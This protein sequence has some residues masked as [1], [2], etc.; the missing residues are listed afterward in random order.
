MTLQC[1]I[2]GDLGFGDQTKGSW[3]DHIARL[4]RK[5]LN[6]RFNGSGQAAHHVLTPE[7]I[8]H[9]FRQFGSAMFI[10]YMITILSRFMLVEPESIF[11]EAEVLE[12]KGVSHPLDRILVSRDCPVVTPCNRLLNQIQEIAR[13]G[14]RHGSVGYGVGITQNDVETLGERALYVRDFNSPDLY[15]K[16]KWLCLKRIEEA[17]KHATPDNAKLRRTLA[18]I[19][20]N[21]F[22]DL[23]RRFYKRVQVISEP[24]LLEMIAT[25]DSVF[26]AAQGLMLDQ[27]YGTFPYCTRSN[28]TFE[29]A[30]TIL[31]EANFSG[32]ITRIGL[33]RGYATRHGHGPFPTEVPNLP[34]PACHNGTNPWQGKFRLGWFDAVSARY[35]LDVTG[36]VDVLAITNLDRMAG[37]PVLKVATSYAHAD[38]RFFSPEGQMLVPGDYDLEW[39]RQRS[40]ALQRVTPQYAE[41]PVWQAGDTAG[42]IRYLDFL[43][44]LLKHRI[45]AYSDTPDHH[46]TYLP[47]TKGVI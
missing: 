40:H 25:E 5:R 34:I 30:L 28:T 18:H 1:H 32:Q 6:V 9:C 2:V 35:A 15:D 14:S 19:D 41:H 17:E 45:H 23:Y 11:G 10:P 22:V 4:L 16:L 12:S 13:S 36:G 31:R 39:L 42:M 29:N 38:A 44:E 26:E 47:A 21:F 24:Q 20:L 33:L 7:G 43:S 8:V 3:T 27:R 37:L 46:K